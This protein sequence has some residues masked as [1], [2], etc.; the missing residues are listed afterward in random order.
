MS[1]YKGFN[2]ILLALYAEEI[3][4]G[5]FKITNVNE[6]SEQNIYSITL[7]LSERMETLAF[8]GCSNK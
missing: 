4:N 1:I 5:R 8:Y 6:I 2:Y 7:L 3:E